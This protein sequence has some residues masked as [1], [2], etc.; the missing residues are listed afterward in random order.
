MMFIYIPHG[1]YKW[2]SVSVGHVGHV[3][4]ERGRAGEMFTP[5]WL[6]LN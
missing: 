3:E 4:R 6:E 5:R 2:L 1:E